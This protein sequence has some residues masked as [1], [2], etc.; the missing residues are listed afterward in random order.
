[1]TKI[2]ARRQ[3]I[4]TAAAG[5]TRE[6]CPV[7]MAIGTGAHI[8]NTE[9]GTPLALPPGMNARHARSV[10]FPTLVLLPAAALALQLQPPEDIQRAAEEFLLAQLT[11]PEEGKVH[12]SADALDPRLRL[13][14]CES[15]PQGLLNAAT[16]IG[17]RVTVGVRCAKPKW[18]VYVPVRVETELPVLVLRRALDRNSPLSEADVERTTLRVPG[19]S[20]SYITSVEELAGRHLRRESMPGTPLTIDLLIEDVLVRHGQRVTLVAS[21]GGLEVRAQ[22][23]AI[24]DAGPTGRVR[25]LNLASRRIVEGQVESRDLVRVSL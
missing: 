21:A 12:V 6:R 1:V 9:R 20:S 24:T 13:K 17:A 3:E 25:V 7:S 11:P 19:L 2:T 10:W 5:S 23:E 18:T 16:R 14:Q 4:A 15:R 8:L 22:G